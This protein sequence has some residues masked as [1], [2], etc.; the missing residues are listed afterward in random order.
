M[1]EQLK[2]RNRRLLIWMIIFAVALTALVIVWKLT[3]YQN[4]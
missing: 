1:D 3:I 4:V 2:R